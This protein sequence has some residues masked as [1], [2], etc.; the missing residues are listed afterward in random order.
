MTAT[1]T[2]IAETPG[3]PPDVLSEILRGVRLSG[4]VFLDGRFRQ[5]F[6][7]ISPQRWDNSS[8]VAHLRHISVFHLISRGH[9][10]LEIADGSVHDIRAGDVLLLPF[11]AAHRFWSGDN[12][13]FAYAPDLVRPGPIPGVDVVRYGGPGEN[14]ARFVCGF[15]E[16]AELLAAPLFRSLPPLIIERTSDDTVSD[17][18]TNTVRE[19]VQRIDAADQSA[20]YLLSRLMEILFLEVLRR[21][22]ARLPPGTKGVLAATGDAVVGRALSLLHNAPARR[23]TVEM[24]AQEAGASRTV[25]TERFNRLIGKSPMEYLTHWRIQ[26]AAGRLK[27]GNQR[28]AQIS[29]EAGYESEAAFSRAFKR[30][31]G[32]SPGAWRSIS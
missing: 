18:L 9:C 1:P 15:V 19:I 27:A 17:L 4:S 22:A 31:M 21:H 25:L 11:T 7:V 20:T 14:E 2:I 24:L 10:K 26:L 6:G 32:S 16:S 28:L 5:P 13:E 12:P 3:A 23:W 8:A 30:I 29:H